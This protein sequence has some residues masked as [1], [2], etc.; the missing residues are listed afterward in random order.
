MAGVI[1]VAVTSVLDLAEVS[2]GLVF[3]IGV[4]AAGVAGSTDRGQPGAEIAGAVGPGLVAIVAGSMT[5]FGSLDYSLIAGSLLAAVWVAT[6]EETPS[7][8][9]RWFA[10]GGFLVPLVVLILLPLVLDGETLGHDES[11]YALKARQWLEGTPGTGWSAHRG[12]GMS[13]YGYVVLSLGGSEPGLRL[14]GLVGAMALVVGVW[15]LGRVMAGPVVG[16]MA[17][18]AI[19]AGPAVLHR[20]TEYLS[21]VPAAALLVLCMVVVWRQFGDRDQPGYG[22]LWALPLAWGAFYLR[23]QS[24]LSL[25]LIGCVTL[26]LWWPKVRARPGPTIALAGL[27]LAGLIPHFAQA[28]ALTGSP[29]GI[30]TTASSGAV[31]AYVGEGLVDF[32]EQSRW[33]LAGY[34]GPIALVAAIIGVVIA[35]HDRDRRA[36]YWFLLAPAFGQVL[37]LGLIS[38][39]EPRFLF[40]PIALVM[41]AGAVTLQWAMVAR[42]RWGRLV[43]WVSAMVLLG[44]LALSVDSARRAVAVRIVNNEPVELASVVVAGESASA[45]CGVLTSYSPQVTF[46]SGCATMT[47]PT[48]VEPEE[49]V[50]SVPGEVRFMV[51]V[52][53]GKNQPTGP[54]LGAYLEL[55]DGS[56]ILVDGERRDATVLRLAG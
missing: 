12:I 56:P 30:L 45:P 44:S 29:L 5:G 3:L 31:R 48:G 39:G 9:S 35:R 25:A 21:D 13:L 2:T 17:G 8:P 20:S 47:F 49:A 38:H 50:A 46:Y 14:I 16:A 51:L 19:I 18:A 32:L 24:A 10:W 42:R 36:G 34:I 11:A 37:A 7:N 52:E 6:G 27:G 53:N 15:A 33:H 28:T 1:T 23:Y 55:T 22:L 41:V 43:V 54:D 26:A 4:V 40:F